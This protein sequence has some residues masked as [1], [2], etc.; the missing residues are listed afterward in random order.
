MSWDA[1]I[2]L[3]VHAQLRTQT[4]LFSSAPNDFGGE[5]NTCT[6]EVDLGLPGIL[7]VEVRTDEMGYF[8]EKLPSLSV[9]LEPVAPP[10]PLK[11]DEMDANRTRVEPCFCFS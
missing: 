10:P 6:T 9:V 11:L 5:P 4:K 3:E 2:G 1:V 7:P 8:R